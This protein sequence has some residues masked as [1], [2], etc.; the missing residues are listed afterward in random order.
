MLDGALLQG[1]DHMVVLG[2]GCRDTA[3]DKLGL[4]LG[5]P[6]ANLRQSSGSLTA[7]ALMVLISLT[8]M[9]EGPGA[10]ALSSRTLGKGRPAL[11][12]RLDIS[13]AKLGCVYKQ[14]G[15]PK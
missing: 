7:T 4:G 5:K 14:S 12:L 1:L 15:S 9:A 10:A 8:T 6:A 13:M 2:Q 3:S 11:I